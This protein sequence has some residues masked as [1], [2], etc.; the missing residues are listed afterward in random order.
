MVF[1]ISMLF[2]SFCS[3]SIFVVIVHHYWWLL[4]IL[5]PCL[6]SLRE[7]SDRHRWYLSNYCQSLG[8]KHGL[9]L[10]IRKRNLKIM[11][12]KQFVFPTLFKHLKLPQ[13]LQSSFGYLVM[14]EPKEPSDLTFSACA[15]SIAFCALQLSKALW[16]VTDFL[17]S[18]RAGKLGN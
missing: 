11:L 13:E 12:P 3:L 1:G 5:D 15:K 10:G 14:S 7:T 9:W 6:K 8:W 17:K 16:F 18:I 2:C 4:I